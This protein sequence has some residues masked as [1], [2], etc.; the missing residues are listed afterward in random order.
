[1]LQI[2]NLLTPNS[3][4]NIATTFVAVELLLN[5]ISITFKTGGCRKT[6]SR[7]R[8]CYTHLTRVSI[9]KF[10]FQITRI[11]IFIT[12]ARRNLVRFPKMLNNSVTDHS[13]FFST[14]AA[15]GT[16]RL[17]TVWSIK[18]STDLPSRFHIAV[19]LLAQECNYLLQSWWELTGN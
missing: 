18:L 6:S 7:Y 4:I 9:L 3:C 1:M 17:I 19:R 13:F 2:P 16:D 11:S 10:F 12:D 14:A 8:P 5:V 15:D